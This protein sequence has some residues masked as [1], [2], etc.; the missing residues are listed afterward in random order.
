MGLKS[1]LLAATISLSACATTKSAFYP[2]AKPSL[3]RITNSVFKIYTSIECRN[4]DGVSLE[5]YM[6]AGF[7]YK[8]IDG[9]TIVFTAAHVAN[10]HCKNGNV[11]EYSF[12]HGLRTIETQNWYDVAM[13]STKR[14]LPTYD[15]AIGKPKFK[16]WVFIVTPQG[17]KEG[18]VVGE[19]DHGMMMVSAYPFLEKGNSGSPYFKYEDG[20]LFF[21]G[22]CHSIMAKDG[23]LMRVAVCSDGLRLD[24]AKKFE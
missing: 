1:L 19:Y 10:P 18:A 3:D 12:S 11:T 20:E 7:A 17:I 13:M 9:E 16:D 5:G 4:K 2:A 8:K 15:I 22:V 24:K 23:K 6:G 21:L 14:N